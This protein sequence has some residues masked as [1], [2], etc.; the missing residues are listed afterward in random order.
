MI[1]A[2]IRLQ[3]YKFLGNFITGM[4]AMIVLIIVECFRASQGL[5]LG[6]LF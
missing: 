5:E 2:H 1:Y 6:S 3:K 4:R